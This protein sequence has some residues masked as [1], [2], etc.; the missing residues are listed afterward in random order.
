MSE[1]VTVTC[2][3]ITHV[4]TASVALNAAIMYKTALRLRVQFKIIL[5]CCLPRH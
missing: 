5:R 1:L 4:N 2:C 3:V